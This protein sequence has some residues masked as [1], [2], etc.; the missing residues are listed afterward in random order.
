VKKAVGDWQLAMVFAVGCWQINKKQRTNHQIN[1]EQINKS[2]KNKSTNQ[3]RTIQ[4]INNSTHHRFS[5]P[6]VPLWR[7]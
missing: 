1:N 3:Q 4:Q 5:V 7:I 2:T 6:F